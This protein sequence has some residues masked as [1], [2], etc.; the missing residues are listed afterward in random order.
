MTREVVVHPDAGV[1][2]HATAQRLALAA[3][4]AQSVRP[5]VHVVLTGGRIGTRVVEQLAASELL[6]ALD[7]TGLH[8]WWGDERF[9]PT[10][11]DERNDTAVLGAL[12]D[13]GVPDA[14][15]HVVP[16]P[17][18]VGSPEEAGQRYAAELARFAPDGAQVPSFD[19]LVLGVGPDGHVASL[20]PGH[21]A[22]GATGATVGVHGSPKP[23]P[24][25]VSLTLPA[26]DAARRV[27]LVASGAEKADAVAAG[28]ASDDLPCGRVHGTAE[29]LWLLDVEASAAAAR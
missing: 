1:L 18:V 2:A 10:G 19:V 25:R 27:W 5:E 8:L 16:G 28:L 9:E 3:L 20:F 22:L 12:R 13:A 24:E 7:L 6:A 26:I 23:P 21:E 11:S 4:D 17:D 29:T 15:V 14:N